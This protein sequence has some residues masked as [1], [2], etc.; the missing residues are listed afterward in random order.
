MSDR[1]GG[2]AHRDQIADNISRTTQ[3]GYAISRNQ[4]ILNEIGLAAPIW[5]PDG[6]ARAAVQ[7]S[8]SSYRWDEDLLRGKVLPALLETANANS[9]MGQG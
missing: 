8:V 1:N 5:G 4:M 2:R 9:P 7:C 3:D 6:R